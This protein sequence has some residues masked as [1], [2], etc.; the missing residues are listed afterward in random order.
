MGFFRR[1]NDGL[2]HELVGTLRDPTPVTGL[3]VDVSEFVNAAAG[4]KF[5]VIGERHSDPSIAILVEPF[6]QA[7]NRV[8]AETL[9]RGDYSVKGEA[10]K[11]NGVY[12]WNSVKYDRLVEAC[13]DAGVSIH[14]IDL[15]RKEHK[16][17]SS[18]GL[19]SAEIEEHRVKSWAEYII[20]NMRHNGQ[21]VILVGALHVNPPDFT[22]VDLSRI[23]IMLYFPYSV[24]T[25]IVAQLVAS[26]IAEDDIISIATVKGD[27]SASAGIYKTEGPAS[28]KIADFIY[29]T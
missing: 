20:S 17:G 6:L 14:G 3:P 9:T 27:G 23:N 22:S 28:V 26:G 16:E 19:R 13:I 21:N 5:V 11:K 4:K 1:N 7:D 2:R 8:F 24:R 12:A 25:N 29:K 15:T 10:L 18:S